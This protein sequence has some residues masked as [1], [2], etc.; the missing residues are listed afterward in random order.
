MVKST[1]AD[2][3][4][5]LG[6]ESITIDGQSVFA[7]LAEV[8]QETSIMGGSR[9][10]RSLTGQFPTNKSIGLRTGMAVSV[11]KKKWKLESFQRGQAMTTIN[12]IEPNRVSE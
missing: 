2:N 3:M 4:D 12:I 5:T 10:E 6:A 11:G 1:L 8:D 7:I 9:V